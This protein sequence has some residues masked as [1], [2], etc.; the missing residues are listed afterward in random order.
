KVMPYIIHDLIPK[1]VLDAWTTIGELIVLLWHT[2]ICDTES[3]LAKLSKTIDDFLNITTQ[4][5]P[6]ILIMKPKF[7]FLIHLPLYIRRFGPAIVF[8]TERYE[9]FNSVFCLS[10]VHSNHQAPSRDSC[11]TFAR[12]DIIKHIATG[13][14]WFNEEIK[15]WVQGTLA[16]YQE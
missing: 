6:S 2:K 7:H 13:G 5:A 11:K 15:K 16:R 8:S 12:Q 4:C 1:A 9:S 14:Y 3:Y 10:C